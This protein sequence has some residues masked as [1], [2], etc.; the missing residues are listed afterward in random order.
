MTYVLAFGGVEFVASQVQ[1]FQDLG[2]VPGVD[3]TVVGHVLL[4]SL[5]DIH[6]TG[7]KHTTHN[8][9]SIQG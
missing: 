4:T 9:V 3:T 8:T 1:L 5:V 2:H 6:L 7:C